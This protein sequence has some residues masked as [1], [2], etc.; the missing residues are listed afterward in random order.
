MGISVASLEISEVRWL[1][2]FLLFTLLDL[3]LPPGS[4]CQNQIEIVGRLA[5][6]S[7]VCAPFQVLWA[8]L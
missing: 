2:D 6:V 7:V 3:I 4:E 1:L 8:V 5:G